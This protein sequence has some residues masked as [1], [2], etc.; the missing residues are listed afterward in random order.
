MSNPVTLLLPFKYY[1]IWIYKSEFILGNL[2]R[3]LLRLHILLIF[4]KL[5][6][7][8]FFFINLFLKLFNLLFVLYI[9]ASIFFL[10]FHKSTP[11]PT[12]TSIANTMPRIAERF[13]L[14]LRCSLSLL[15]QSH[16]YLS[17][18]RSVFP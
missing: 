10:P 1:L 14:F 7:T 18:L 5:F 9:L 12:T 8:L 13:C 11:R 16:L 4:I 2:L 15:S 3:K 17:I 6:C